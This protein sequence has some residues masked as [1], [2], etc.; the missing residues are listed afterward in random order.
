MRLLLE[1]VESGAGDLA[2]SERGDQVVE[3]RRHAAPDVDEERGALH[4]LEARPVHE[5]LGRRRMRHG[6]DDE[7]RQRQQRVERLGPV[8]L[9]HA[10]GRFATPRVDAHDVHP[11]RRRK[12]C[13]LA[14][15]PADADDQCRGLRQ[16]DH[17]AV[18]GFPPPLSP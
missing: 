12:P 13:R 18:V 2:R 17:P 3:T 11:E 8:E 14:A 1:D 7:V 4:E 10:R 16:V 9:Q 5:V 15:D 6:Q